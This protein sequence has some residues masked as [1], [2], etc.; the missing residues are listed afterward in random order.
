MAA[1]RPS[2]D[3]MLTHHPLDPLT[4]DALTLGTQ[5]GM[6]SRRAIVPVVSMNSP[7]IAQ[8]RAIGESR[9]GSATVTAGVV[10]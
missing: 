10:A 2:Q 8:Q 4:A 7:D 1:W 9:A 5:L 6:N 3:T